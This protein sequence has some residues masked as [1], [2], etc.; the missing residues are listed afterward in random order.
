[1]W[2]ERVSLIL[3]LLLSVTLLGGIFGI[4]CGAALEVLRSLFGQSFPLVLIAFSFAAAF[5]LIGSIVQYFKLFAD[6]G[7]PARPLMSRARALL[8]LYSLVALILVAHF[9]A[10]HLCR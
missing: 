9:S 1:M 6:R 7:T 4:E 5:S 3:S 10:T 2:K 8:P